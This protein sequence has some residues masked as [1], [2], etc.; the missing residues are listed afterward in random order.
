MEN[1]SDFVIEKG[2]LKAY[3]GK[4][5]HVEIPSG[6]KKIGKGAF[7]AYR[8]R[9][10]V[11]V[12]IPDGVTEI[13]IEAFY[14]LEKLAE[15]TIPA[16]LKKIGKR[17]FC[18]CIS[19]TNIVL[20]DG[21]AEIEEGTFSYC[22]KLASVHLPEGLMEIS[23]QLFMS[24]DNLEEVNIPEK[25]KII[26][27]DA[28]SGCSKLSA[29]HLPET[30]EKI[31]K[32]AFRYC[33]E[34]QKIHIP[35]KC[36][37]E[38]GAFTC[39]SGLVDENGLLILQNRLYAHYMGDNGEFS[40]T[41]P[42]NVEAIELGALMGY[43]KRHLEVNIH[44]PTWEVSGK[45][46]AYGFARSIIN[47]NGSTISFRDDSGTIVA[48]VV[49]ATEDETEPKANGAILSIR[50]ENHAFD[51]AG[52]DDYWAKLGKNPNKIRVALVR[53]QYP[54]ALS[55][56]MQE[57]YETFLTKQSLNAGK[58]LIDEDQAELLVMMAEKQLFSQT[59]LP[60]LV[61]YANQTGKIA[62]TAQLLAFQN[63][64][65]EKPVAK[66][67]SKPKAKEKSMWKKPKA[68]TCLVG[69]Y[70]GTETE[71]TFPT[72]VEGISIEGIANTTGVTPANYKALRT[73]VIPEGYTSIGN[74][75]FAGCEKLES[76]IFP[77]SLRSIGSG[78]FGMGAYD[79]KT[80]RGK[81]CPVCSNLREL[82]IPKE[83][84]LGNDVFCDATIRVM[85]MGTG[86]WDIPNGTFRNCQIDD[87]VIIGGDCK[88]KGFL[89]DNGYKTEDRVFPKRIWI[90]GSF[91]CRDIRDYPYLIQQVHPLSEFDESIIHDETVRV[92]VTKAKNHATR[93]N[94]QPVQL[95]TANQVE[96]VEFPG[97]AFVLSGFKYEDEF[98]IRESLECQGAAIKD[99]VSS[100][101]QYLLIPDGDVI[102]TAKY[103]KAIELQE[104]GKNITILTLSELNRHIRSRNES[105]YGADGA[106]AL[107]RFRITQENGE[108]CLVRYIGSETDVV[109]PKKIGP[110]P[111]TSLAKR[112]FARNVMLR[113]VDACGEIRK[114]VIQE[115]ITELPD[116]L[117]YYCAKL[118]SVV[119]P[120]GLTSIGEE[121][122]HECGNLKQIHLPGSLREIGQSA[123][124]HCRNLK[125]MV[126]PEGL[127]TLKGSA[128]QACTGLTRM[129]IPS[130]VS[131]IESPFTGC[132]NLTEIIVDSAN[133]TYDSRENC[134]AIIET[135]TGVLVSGCQT[136]V[137]P[138]G[139]VSIGE[140]AFG[141][142]D[143]LTNVVVPE[144]VVEL[145]DS[146]F[147]GCR[148]LK[149]IHLPT[150]LKRIG[151]D[152]FSWCSLSSIVLPEHLELLG[153]SAFCNCFQL[154]SVN[155]PVGVKV[156]EKYTFYNCPIRCVS[157]SE[158]SLAQD[159][160]T[161]KHARYIPE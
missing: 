79:E 35:E 89:F 87:L 31:G 9:D 4:S 138:N 131:H 14:Q 81:D 53:L 76:V 134:N 63:T 117:F 137:F 67:E 158:A 28:F 90:N 142:L 133:T 106:D 36:V 95:A 157:G 116:Q 69:R 1:L 96:N 88:A 11:S 25:V 15:V 23:A 21:V 84:S 74:R 120:E 101:T 115:N 92:L 24:C 20:P 104:K 50:Q 16:S 153:D 146:A 59:S 112:C 72:E 125:E 127:T 13:G 58:L 34:L 18:W 110:Y 51:F 140:C 65:S 10:I 77:A 100:K 149:S 159:V 43:G 46:K 5:T 40:V 32:D 6:I 145:R 61:D 143:C 85:V 108:V 38:P 128:F 86:N 151:I 148:K 93:E 54:Y 7:S 132:D 98:L 64:V 44:C 129:V 12:T 48:K 57:V 139:V 78:A 113:G 30:V 39:C 150:T 136:T 75:A 29:I 109:V 73:V 49:L 126:L 135:A 80:P 3:N 152:A 71:I 68:G 22:D 91:D 144:G 160:A 107:E 55:A 147:S 8:C 66:K 19:L 123:F 154:E 102:K 103:K 60:K 27:P 111:V 45:A 122:F 42:D 33:E 52:Y 62:L 155:I 121:A 161:R 130:S 70:L 124:N 47:S 56:E 141:G 114:V 105:I 82:Y 99:S 94:K 118:E 37:I 156:I 97:N 2:V 26:G 41:I 83:V 119:L 17:A